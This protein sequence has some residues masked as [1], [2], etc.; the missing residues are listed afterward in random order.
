MC[1][2]ILWGGTKHDPFIKMVFPIIVGQTFSTKFDEMGPKALEADR[3]NVL[4]TKSYTDGEVELEK[5][6]IWYFH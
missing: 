5:K 4:Y 6:T 3:K 1:Y 2:K